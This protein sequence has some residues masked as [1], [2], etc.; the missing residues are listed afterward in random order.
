MLSIRNNGLLFLDGEKVSLSME[1]MEGF[2]L[3]SI[4]EPCSIDGA[5]MGD[6]MN[7]FFHVQSFIRDYFIEEYHAINAVVST[8]KL[9]ESVQKIEFSKAMVIDGD[10]YAFITPHVNIQTGEG[11]VTELKN[12]VVVLTEVLVISGDERL[13]D[14]KL[15]G[16]F[17]LLEVMEAL[18][19]EFSHIVMSSSGDYAHIWSL[20]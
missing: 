7:V 16:K 3:A 8:M 19:S 17:T 5:T 10:G 12:A 6:M 4:S 9:K 2:L 1:Q 18:F 20:E 14:V 11:G 15:K 13:Q